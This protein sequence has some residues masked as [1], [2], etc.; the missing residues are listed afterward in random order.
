MHAACEIP[1]P[2]LPRPIALIAIDREGAA[3]FSL[4]I[5]ARAC[6]LFNYCLQAHT[7][8]IAHAGEAGSG[9][10]VEGSLDCELE[11]FAA[12]EHEFWLNRKMYVFER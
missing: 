7:Q 4:D 3:Q 6:S 5:Q 11:Y 10:V 2:A 12:H 1:S 8:Q 9:R